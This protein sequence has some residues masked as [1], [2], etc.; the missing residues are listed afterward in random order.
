VG[1]TP[2]PGTS[3][4]L[5]PARRLRSTPAHPGGCYRL[6]Q[7]QVTG[8]LEVGI[9]LPP[10]HP[11]HGS[12]TPPMHSARAFNEMSRSTAVARIWTKRAHA[13]CKVRR[14]S[15]PVCLG[16]NRLHG[17]HASIGRDQSTPAALLHV[18][19]VCSRHGQVFVPLCGR[20]GLAVFAQRAL[21]FRRGMLTF[22]GRVGRPSPSM[23]AAAFMAATRPAMCSRGEIEPVWTPAFL[24][25]APLVAPKSTQARR[26][27]Q[28]TGS[29]SLFV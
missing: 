18:R 23:P 19:L 25:Q 28:R 6:T 20:G 4:Q 12:D 29:C 10:P 27:H 22:G 3:G 7:V 2:P 21:L 5:H 24:N 1:P 15:T 8:D 26:P 17:R 9:C 14:A 16:T 13:P 11:H